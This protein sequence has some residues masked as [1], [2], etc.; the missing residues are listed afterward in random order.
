M[1]NILFLITYLVMTIHATAQETKS[2]WLIAQK[3]LF[4]TK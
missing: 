4:L 3:P 1:K 2:R